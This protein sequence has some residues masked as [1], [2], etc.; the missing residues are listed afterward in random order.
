MIVCQ[1]VKAFV[2]LTPAYKNSDPEKLV[3]ELQEHVK[4]LTA[5]YKYPRK[6]ATLFP[7]CFVWSGDFQ[8][9]A[10]D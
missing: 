6:V 5:P 3:S 1:V 4:K 8:L 10:F 2:T 7:S 9:N